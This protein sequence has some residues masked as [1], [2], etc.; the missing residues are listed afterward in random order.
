MSW[1]M[2]V[3]YMIKKL[4]SY[5][6]TEY[7]KYANKEVL[8]KAIDEKKYIFDLKRKF[9]INEIEL[10]DSRIPIYLQK[11]NIFD[12]MEKQEIPPE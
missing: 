4:H 12:Y 9:D 10:N 7:R 11:D 5:S 2:P 1:I 6:H 8:T 3:D